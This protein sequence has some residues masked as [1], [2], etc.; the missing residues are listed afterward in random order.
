MGRWGAEVVATDERCGRRQSRYLR[1]NWFDV[2]AVAAAVAALPE[3]SSLFAGNSLPVRHVDQ[4]APPDGKRIDVYGNRGASGIDGVV[5]SALG[6]AA[7]D[8]ARQ[9]LLIIGDVSFYHDMNGLLA[10]NRLG[11]DNV[12]ILLLNNGGGGLFRRLPIAEDGARF[13]E[14]FLTPTDLDFSAAAAMYG[15]EHRCIHDEDSDALNEAFYASLHGDGPTIIEVRTDGARDE[16]LRRGTDPFIERESG[17]HFVTIPQSA[18]WQEVAEY[19]DIT[20]HKADGMARIAFDRPEKRNAF[21]PET[22]DQ[23]TEAFK[24]SLGGRPGWRGTSDGQWSFA[25]GRGTRILRGGRP[26][27]AGARRLYGRTGRGAV[28]CARDA[29]DH[30][31]YA[32]A[33]YRPGKRVRDRWRPR[34]ARDLRPFTGFGKRRFRADWADSGQFRRRPWG[35]VPGFGCRPEEG[36]GDLVP[37]PQVFGAGGAGDGVGEQG[38]A[39]GGGIGRGGRGLGTGDSAQVSDRDSFSEGGFQ[40]GSGWTD[41]FAGPCRRRHDALLYD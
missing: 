36:E 27:R 40:R 37:V 2:S 22:I 19:S 4:F 15:L 8:R 12:T 6:A 32:Q 23:M 17:G 24:D 38:L 16:R 26:G 25:E 34:A 1:E 39:D 30:A 10:I 20:Y 7:A 3:G 29:A 9:M 5:S 13:E 33:D 31:Q 18:D 14:L 35:I 11:L 28:E 21:R 41:R